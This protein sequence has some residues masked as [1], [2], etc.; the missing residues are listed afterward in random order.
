[1]TKIIA[2]MHKIV[3]FQISLT[4]FTDR[5]KAQEM[6]PSPEGREL[7][8]GKEPVVWKGDIG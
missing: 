5:F 3:P 8:S 7:E 4:S 6:E 1:M 2:I